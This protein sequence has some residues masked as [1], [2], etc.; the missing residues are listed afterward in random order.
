MIYNSIE[1]IYKKIRLLFLK[2]VQM[3]EQKKIRVESDNRTGN[4]FIHFEK[5]KI[6]KRGVN[7]N[8]TEC[9]CTNSCRG[10]SALYLQWWELGFGPGI[11]AHN[12]QRPPQSA[13]T[14]RVQVEVP[15]K[16]KKQNILKTT[17]Y[18]SKILSLQYTIFLKLSDFIVLRI[19]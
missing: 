8:K 6:N 5:W 11:I 3:M 12:L 13:V 9:L 15:R 16:Q 17:F 19:F 7:R 14:C 1:Q 10:E 18:K 4:I 2:K